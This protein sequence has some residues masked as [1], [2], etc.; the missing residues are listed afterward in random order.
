MTNAISTSPACDFA[1][2]LAELQVELEANQTQ[3]AQQQRDAARTSYLDNIQKQVD[4]LHKAADATRAGALVNASMQ[5]AGSVCEL[6]AVGVQYRIDSNPCAAGADW[7]AWGTAFSKV[8]DGLTKL[9]QPFQV[10]VGDSSAADHQAEAKRYESRAEQAQWQSQDASD[11]ITK[12]SKQLDAILDA[13]RQLL[14]DQSAAT[15]T[16]IGRI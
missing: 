3:S 1:M 6:S 5:L 12:A 9:A 15:N 2:G 16:I 4:E 7:A 13:T 11:E 10:L 8:G 14:S